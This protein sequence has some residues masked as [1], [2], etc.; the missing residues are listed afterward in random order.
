MRPPSMALLRPSELA[1]LWKLHPNTVNAWIR[2]GRLVAIKTPGAQ[3]R[4]REGDARAFCQAQGLPMPKR[5]ASPGGAILLLGKPSPTQ[6]AIARACKERRA[7]A[8][9]WTNVLDGLLAI[10]A[11]PPDVVALDAEGT[12]VKAID[13]LRAL[14]RHEVSA[15]LPVV[16]H[17]AGARHATFKLG[18]TTIA[19]KQDPEEAVRLVLD[20][21]E[22]KQR[23]A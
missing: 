18:P 11:N 4:V 22:Q 9:A 6:R 8:R 1:R 17:D 13:V 21:F 20:V 14:R 3:Y 16:V 19:T 23:R 5:V 12:D 2:E 10:A 15:N 7:S